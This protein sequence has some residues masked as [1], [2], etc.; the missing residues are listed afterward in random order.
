[1]KEKPA[2]ETRHEDAVPSANEIAASEIFSPKVDTTQRHNLRDVLAASRRNTEV[3]TYE[4]STEDDSAKVLYLSE[5]LIGDQATDIDFYTKTIETVRELPEDMQPHLLVLSG[6]VQGDFKFLEK[7]R[8]AN[9]A[10]GFGSMDTQFAYAREMLEEAQT[11]GVPIIYNMSNDDLRIAEEYTYEVMRQLASDH[12]RYAKK[13]NPDN[14]KS[15]AFT[16]VSALDKLRRHPQFDE[17]L[18]FQVKTVFPYCLR[19]GRRLYTAEEMAEM[20]NGKIRTEEY[21]VLFDSERRRAAGEE[22]VPSHASWLKRVAKEQ[23]SQESLIIEDNL[24]LEVMT[25]ERTYNDWIRHVFALSDKTLSRSYMKVAVE[26]VN[27]EAAS[28][29]QQPDMLIMQNNLEDVGVSKDNKWIVSTGGMING[30]QYL[31]TRGLNTAPAGG[32]AKR[33]VTARRRTAVPSATMHDRTD[34]GRHLVTFF[35]DSL[36]EKSDSIPERITIA[37]LCDFQTGSITARP[38]LLAK[39]LDYIRTRSMGERAT[40]LFFGGDMMHGRNYPNFPSES[41]LTGLMAMDSQEAFNTAL[42][43]HAFDGVTGDE[44]AALER[45]LVQPG[46]HE[47]NSGTLNWHGYSFVS[48]MRHFFEKMLARGGYSDT[49][50]AEIVKTND[51]VITPKGEYASGYTGIEY[52]GD[53]GVLIQHYL[54][55]RGGK[56]SGGDLPVYQGHDFATGGGDLMQN[57]DILMAGHWH[58]PQYALLGNKLNVIGGSIAGISDYELKRSYRPTIAGTQLHIGGGLP[59]QVEFI[60]EEA[61]HRHEIQT[62]G[63]TRQQ[64]ADEGY[65]DDRGFDPVRHGIFMPDRFAKS[66]LQKKLLQLGRDA[67]QRT[68]TLAEFR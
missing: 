26:A 4:F 58:H 31:Q 24:N 62:G 13:T 66:A 12:K 51:A 46:N 25:N 42:F 3:S 22:V 30:R 38:D 67:A 55:E 52:F 47:W 15:E 37:E 53:M 40:A 28:G 11:I 68:H 23:L 9:L 39:Y 10:Q 5:L 43:Q 41:Q 33:S 61:L 14:W 60:S 19:S 36:L 48:Y 56:G 17:H 57:I 54:L 8:R 6:L 45:V 50:I 2:K 1:M 21:Y 16:S 65:R 7:S 49:E 44:L 29:H 64:L 32:A 59:P 20:T 63:F 18:Q 27:Q 35:N 34:D